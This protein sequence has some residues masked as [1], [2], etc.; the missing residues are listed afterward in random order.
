MDSEKEAAHKANYRVLRE[1]AFDTP[2]GIAGYPPPTR[3]AL[4]V[5]HD[6]R[7][8]SYEEKWAEG[9][10]ISFLYTYKDLLLNKEANDTAADF[11]RDKIRQIVKDPKV[12]EKL[13]PYDH[14]IGTKRLILDSGYFETYNQDN[15]TLVDIREAPI[16]RFTPEGLRTADGNDYELDAVVFATGFDADRGAAQY[17][18]G[19]WSRTYH[20]GQMVEWTALLHGAGDGRLPKSVHDHRTSEPIGKDSD[21]PGW[22]AAY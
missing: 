3:S 6:E 20:P 11:V 15:V 8:A 12:A 22:P 13:I 14:P 17:R 5:P 2:F 10:S 19:Q 4:D 7:Q 1:A 9:G 16:E 18:T 21:D